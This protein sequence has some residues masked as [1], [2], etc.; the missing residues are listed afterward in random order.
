MNG[1]WSNQDRQNLQIFLLFISHF[2]DKYIS[3]ILTNRDPILILEIVDMTQ[4]SSISHK[5][6]FAFYF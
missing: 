1:N 3:L 5:Q 6:K 4:K 2:P